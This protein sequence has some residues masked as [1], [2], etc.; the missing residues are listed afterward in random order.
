MKCFYEVDIDSMEEPKLRLLIELPR[1]T[2]VLDLLAIL[3]DSIRRFEVF[4]NNIDEFDESTTFFPFIV[5]FFWGPWRR[6]QV[7]SAF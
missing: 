2:L 4:E 7:C 6:N 3:E 1:E 5:Y